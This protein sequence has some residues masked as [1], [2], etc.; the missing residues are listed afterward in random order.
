MSLNDDLVRQARLYTRDLSGTLEDLVAEFVERH[1]PPS[2]R[3][4]Q[5]GLQAP[6]APIGAASLSLRARFDLHSPTTRPIAPA[7]PYRDSIASR[8]D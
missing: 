8:S 3:V 5:P 1:R 6:H 4:S 2:I 7:L